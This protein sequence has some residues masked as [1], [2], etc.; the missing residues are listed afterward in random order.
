MK[1]FVALAL[2]VLILSLVG[3]TKNNTSSSDI[4]SADNIADSSFI[5]EDITSESEIE[6]SET[7]DISEFKKVTSNKET[8]STVSNESVVANNS[9]AATP[10]NKKEEVNSTTSNTNSS[11]SATSSTPTESGSSKPEIKTLKLYE[12]T[13][14]FGF[15]GCFV[16]GNNPEGN[17]SDKVNEA[18]G[19]TE[20]NY[21]MTEYYNPEDNYAILFAFSYDQGSCREIVDQIDE[22]SLRRSIPVK[23]EY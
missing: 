11:E 5:E 8:N 15:T 16:P 7:T 10:T 23:L 14:Y 13:T 22:V 2:S 4:S 6:T 12:K 19:T 17:T 21:A 9:S 18:L 3:C 1:K 20:C